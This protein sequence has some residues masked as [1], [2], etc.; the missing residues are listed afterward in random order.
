MCKLFRFF[1]FNLGT[2]SMFV[3]LTFVTFR[4]NAGPYYAK[5]EKDIY[6]SINKTTQTV[7]EIFGMVSSQSHLTFTYDESEVD[8]HQQ[9]KL[10][11]GRIVLRDLLSTISKQT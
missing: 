10:Q 11:T 1:R 3:L 5:S 4:A 8:L 9:V 2:A 6:I 7:K